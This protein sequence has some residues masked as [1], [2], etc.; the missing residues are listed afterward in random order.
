MDGKVGLTDGLRCLIPTCLT[1]VCVTLS[2]VNRVAVVTGFIGHDSQ[3]RVTTLGRGGSDL[4]A[5]TL[6]AAVGVD[7]IQVWKDVNGASTG[8][9][10][11][12]AHR[13]RGLGAGF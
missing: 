10:V 12:E 8:I 3:G 13:G 4:T 6:G 5:S 2:C 1:M 7:E 11:R 9:R